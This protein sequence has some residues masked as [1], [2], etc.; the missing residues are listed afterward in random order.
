MII[1]IQLFYVD[2]TQFLNADLISRQRF[3]ESP[4]SRL[5][6]VPYTWPLPPNVVRRNDD[7][8][9]VAWSSNDNDTQGRL[10]LM[11]PQFCE[12]GHMTCDDI[13]LLVIK[14]CK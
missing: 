10:R 4:H 6:L 8:E 12:M 3:Q 11:T 14:H 1:H 13:E 2:V 9:V 5:M 7:K